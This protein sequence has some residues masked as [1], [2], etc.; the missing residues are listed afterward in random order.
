MQYV[1]AKEILPEQLL[2]ELQQYAEGNLIYIP[3][4][5][6]GERDSRSESRRLLNERNAEIRRRKQ[7]GA[8]IDELMVDYFLSYDSIKR[9]VYKKT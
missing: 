1:N 7:E 4:M 2:R 3:R 9:I 8:S 6:A 5:T